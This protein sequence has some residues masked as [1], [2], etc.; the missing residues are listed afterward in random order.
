M[1]KTIQANPNPTV[2]PPSCTFCH[3]TGRVTHMS[4]MHKMHK[5]REMMHKMHKMREMM[6]KMHK[7]REMRYKASPAQKF[8]QG[9]PAQI[10]RPAPLWF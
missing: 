4:Q 6:H 8:H 2:P 1:Y 10:P 5:M 3:V 9:E 7:M